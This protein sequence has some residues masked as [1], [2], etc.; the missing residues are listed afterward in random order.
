MQTKENEM[1]R[2]EVN[3]HA[4]IEKVW[5]FWTTPNHIMKW[6]QASEDW[7]TTR[8]MIDLRNGG[9]F[10]YRMEARD[11]STGF[12]F[13]GKYT[14]VIKYKQISIVL[15]DGRRVDIYF[16]SHE[17]STTIIE[18]FEPEN[19]NSPE[20]QKN[21]WQAI[22]DNFKKCVERF[23]NLE[24]LHFEISI[25][26]KPEQVFT[27]MLDEKKYCDWT[28]EFNPTSRYKGSWSKNSKILFLGTNEDGSTGGM[29]S[30]IKENIENSFISI[31][32]IGVVQGEKETSSGPEVEGWSGF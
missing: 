20:L 32:H 2:V 18:Q 3:V 6:N 25:Q 9:Q 17:E 8:A 11:G 12:D 26:A 22:L 28:A 10:N 29:T 1:I 23:G 31:E 24:T 30:R 16:K 14:D 13:A 27:T 4:P 15:G 19:M 7:Q 21:G 5:Q